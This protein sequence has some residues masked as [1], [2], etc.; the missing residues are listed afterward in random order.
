MQDF[1]EPEF[2][3][4]PEQ[5][6]VQCEIDEAA[7]KFKL[8]T[9]R[10]RKQRVLIC[11]EISKLAM[12]VM[13]TDLAFEAAKMAVDSTWDANKDT[14]LVIAQSQAHNILAQC[15]VECLLEEEIEIGHKDLVTLDGDQE[16]REFTAE[17]TAKFAEHKSKFVN[18][19][20]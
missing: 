7:K 1:E 9:V 20:N 10:E 6:L 5:N 13:L 18:H 3:V 8:K 19:I 2:E 16:D 17:Q 11:T 15:Y 4:L 12:E 14:D